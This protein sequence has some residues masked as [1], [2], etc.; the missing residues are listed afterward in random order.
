MAAQETIYWMEEALSLKLG[1]RTVEP[2]L[3]LKLYTNNYTPTVNSTPGDFTELNV[4]GYAA[5]TLTTGGWSSVSTVAIAKKTRSDLTWNFTAGFPS[6]NGFWGY[7]VVDEAADPPVV[8][9]AEKLSAFHN[10]P[11]SGESYTIAPTVSQQ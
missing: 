10:I 7:Y 1:I 2:V 11:T 4:S 6:T 9:V 8:M 3:K 5:K